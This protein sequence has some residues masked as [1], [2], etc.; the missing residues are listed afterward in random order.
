MSDNLICDKLE[1]ISV[2]EDEKTDTQLETDFNA[3]NTLK[4]NN[5]L[6]WDEYFMSVAL[7]SAQRSKDPSRQVGACVVNPDNKIVSVGYNGL[8][9]GCDD[10]RFPWGKQGGFLET[11]YAYVCHAEMNAVVNR[12]SAAVNGCRIY[13]TL[14]PC[15]ECTKLLI[16]SGIKEVIYGTD[17]YHDE[18]QFV[19]SR[20]MLKSAGVSERRFT[21]T[22]KSITLSFDFNWNFSNS[23]N[24]I[25]W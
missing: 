10:D 8:P 17:N 16:Q 2:V 25:I 7:L 12:N 4:R 22:R 18:K 15:N 6:S 20:R 3:N 24:W 11:K 9:V 13:V 21:T 5:Y 14:F 1:E 23:W 19:A